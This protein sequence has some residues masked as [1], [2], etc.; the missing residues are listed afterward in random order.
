MITPELISRINELSHKKRSVGL[1]PEEQTEQQAL[2]REYL[3]N[4]REQVKG[5]L[6]Q[7]EIVD[8]PQPAP[9]VTRINEISFSLRRQLH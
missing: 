8:A 5:M 3:N 6:D 4:I 7:I 9:K 1:T 2:R